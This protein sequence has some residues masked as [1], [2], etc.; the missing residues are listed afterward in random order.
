MQI[1]LVLH[2]P[3]HAHAARAKSETNSL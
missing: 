2:P 3:T 1:P